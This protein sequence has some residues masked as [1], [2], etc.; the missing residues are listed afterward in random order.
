[1]ADIRGHE[2]TVTVN[3]N[4]L[5]VT[6][7]VPVGVATTGGTVGG[8]DGPLGSHQKEEPLFVYGTLHFSLYT[9]NTV[10]NGIHTSGL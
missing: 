5:G 8:K 7:D 3:E 1:M 9:D 10:I 6:A 4:I 2:S